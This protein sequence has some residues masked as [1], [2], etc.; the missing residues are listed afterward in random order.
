MIEL[1]LI[2]FADRAGWR[3]WL[4]RN[5]ESSQG[6]WLAIGKKGN[7]ITSLMYEDAVEE[8]VRFNWIDSM[9]QAL[10]DARYRQMFTPRKPGSEWSRSNK[11]RVQRLTEAG[12]M[13]PIALAA[14]EAAK[15]DG[16]WSALDDV[17][18][19]VVPDDLAAALDAEPEAAAN[20]ASFTDSARKAILYWIATA[21][22][23]ETRARRIGKTVEAVA[24]GRPPR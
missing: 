15:A 20:F 24:E 1:P 21:K 19:L 23:E 7:P 14:V 9:A 5:S 18:D 4:D 2:E 3:A 17:E 12:M 6:V 10:D 13:T 8:A 22:R 11:E 16:S